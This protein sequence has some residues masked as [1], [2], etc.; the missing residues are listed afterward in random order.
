MYLS[1]RMKY[2]HSLP[3]LVYLCIASILLIL[4]FPIESRKAV[5]EE[6][7]FFVKKE[8]H[9]SRQHEGEDKIKISESVTESEI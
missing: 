8:A 7:E 6:K 5:K 3:A 9:R 2:Y 4:S 1:P